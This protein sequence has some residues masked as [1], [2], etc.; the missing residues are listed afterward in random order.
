ML[1]CIPTEA[2]PV[3]DPSG[4]GPVRLVSVGRLH[5]KKG[6]H[7]VLAAVAR[8][9]DDG[10]AATLRIV[11][12]G[13]DGASLRSLAESLGIGSRVTWHGS[14]SHADLPALYA[15]A[16]LVAVPSV[17]DEA[18]DRDGLPNVLLEALACERPVVASRAGAIESAIVDGAT[19]LLVPPGDAGALAAAIETVAGRTDLARAVARGGREVVERRYDVTAC[20]RRFAETLEVA[21][22]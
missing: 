13:P 17:I 2:V 5:W 21:Y 7:H 1:Q 19:G 8:L 18:G 4:P 14:A 15:A 16:H 11:G 10:V 12:D 6:H 9:R 22:D 20:A 3:A